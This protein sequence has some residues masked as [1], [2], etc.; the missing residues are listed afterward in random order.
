M[1]LPIVEQ[2]ARAIER[3]WSRNH[4]SIRS[5]PD[6]AW[7]VWTPEAEAALEASGLAELTEVLRD[8]RDFCTFLSGFGEDN[9]WRPAS[10]HSALIDALL[11]KLNG[12]SCVLADGPASDM[13]DGPRTPHGSLG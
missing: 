4:A 10:R 8:M 13:R 6:I 2:V 9:I 7:R 1:T 12:A 3:A 11:A 5:D